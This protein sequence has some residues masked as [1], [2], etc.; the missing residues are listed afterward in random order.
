MMTTRA[1]GWVVVWMRLQVEFRAVHRLDRRHHHRYVFGVAP[2]I[3]ALSGDVSMVARPT[4]A[5]CLRSRHP[6][7]PAPLSERMR[8]T[9]SRSAE[10]RQPVAPA[11]LDARTGG[12]REVAGRFDESPQQPVCAARVRIAV[13]TRPARRRGAQCSTQCSASCGFARAARTERVRHHRDRQVGTAERL[14]CARPSRTKAVEQTTT[15][16]GPASPPLH[17]RGH[18]TTCSPLSRRSR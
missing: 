1:A 18:S 16:Q 12:T 13:R 7:A 9:R 11:M 5:R 17:C 4:P 8:A 10:C 2:A 6:A 3:T 15:R 14:D